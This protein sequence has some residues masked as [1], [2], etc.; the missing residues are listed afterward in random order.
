[1]MLEQ[2]SWISHKSQCP[3]QK[4]GIELPG[5]FPRSRD[6]RWYAFKPAFLDQSFDSLAGVWY[7]P[8]TSRSI[9]VLL[10]YDE[11]AR[12]ES[13]VS[14]VIGRLRKELLP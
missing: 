5:F 2:W 8:T 7:G 9:A 14:D 13:M 10:A 11:N 4:L 3:P 1:M 12:L 6:G